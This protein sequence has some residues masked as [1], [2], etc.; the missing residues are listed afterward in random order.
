MPRL[1]DGV[2]PDKKDTGEP[3]RR[4]WEERAAQLLAGFGLRRMGLE[5]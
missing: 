2:G 1:H 3:A 5:P 4:A